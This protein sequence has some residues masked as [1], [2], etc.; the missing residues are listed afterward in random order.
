MLQLRFFETPPDP[1]ILGYPPIL[2]VRDPT[3]L[4]TKLEGQ[5]PGFELDVRRP[6]RNFAGY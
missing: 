2:P 3:G 6:H 4:D 5:Q 1:P